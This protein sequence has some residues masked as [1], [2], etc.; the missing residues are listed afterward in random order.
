M[1]TRSPA[2]YTIL[3]VPHP[4]LSIVSPVYRAEACLDELYQQ[5]R[6]ACE[7]LTA[8]FEIV[9]V[10]DGSPDRSWSK[11]QELAAAD[12][13]VKIIRLSRNFGQH[14]A[15][16]A[17][18]DHAEGDFVVVMDCDL[19]H[20]PRAIPDLY[21]VAQQPNTDIVWARFDTK[22]R[23]HSLLKR[24]NSWWFKK[25]Y[26]LL[27][28]V[29]LDP[30]VSNYTMI[31]R[32]VVLQ[33]RR[34]RERERSYPLMLGW[35]GFR[36]AYC[37]VPHTPRFAGETSYTLARQV[38]FAIANITAHSN[39]PLLLSIGVGFAISASAAA[40][41]AYLVWKYYTLGTSVTGWTSTMVTLAALGGV[42]L[43]N[44]GVLG[45]YVGKIFDE[46][47]RRPLYVMSEWKNLPQ[48]EP[49]GEPLD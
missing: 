31:T 14:F 6:Q 2:G 5:I 1:A 21:R 10:E 7:Q 19:E 8:D 44:L 4:H 38:T 9:L 24:F 33:L 17:G 46:L 34:L 43:I 48:S 42:L 3:L 15:I 12:D 49:N 36:S 29:P 22:A 16:T 20:D 11:M 35:L 18:L 40:Y 30:R 37:D 47:K 45:L 28:S 23:S 27:S 26:A 32:Y 41:G 25:L 39:R 13:R